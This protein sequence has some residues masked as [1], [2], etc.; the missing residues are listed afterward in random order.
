MWPVVLLAFFGLHRL[1]TCARQIM[2]KP[3]TIHSS[4]VDEGGAA[5]RLGIAPSTLRNI[6]SQGRGPKF[7][8][9]GRRIVYRV[10]DVDAYLEAH[11]EDPEDSR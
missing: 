7:C 11:L 9:I 3:E 2:S 10:I 1:A 5:A 6:R 8:R 4:V